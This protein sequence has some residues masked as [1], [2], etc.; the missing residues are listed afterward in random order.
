MFSSHHLN[1]RLTSGQFFQK[2]NVKD[3]C[4][5]AGVW[6]LTWASPVGKGI[7][8]SEAVFRLW[9]SPR[10]P[11]SL[12]KCPFFKTWTTFTTEMWQ[13]TTQMSHIPTRQQALRSLFCLMQ[14][15]R[16]TH[17]WFSFWAPPPLQA[18]GTFLRFILWD[19]ND[20]SSDDKRPCGCASLGCSAQPLSFR[21]V[22]EWHRMCFRELIPLLPCWNSTILAGD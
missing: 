1:V 16:F 8:G 10:R 14:Q 13:L 19:R 12:S 3:K 11:R 5:Y 15:Q 18:R 4:G 9:V 22:D 17:K 20:Y 6:S 2:T 21:I 7:P